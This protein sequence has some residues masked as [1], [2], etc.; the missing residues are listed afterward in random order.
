MFVAG[1]LNSWLYS[2]G[3]RA[4]PGSEKPLRDELL[5]IERLEER[6]LALAARFTTVA[7]GS[8]SGARSLFPRFN[9][10]ARAL[11]DAYRALA[12]DGHRGEFVTPAGEW[13]LDNYH[14]VAAEIR[15]VHQDL[16]RGYY[17]ELPKLA[18]RDQAGDARGYA[19]AV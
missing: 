5:S 19:L 17:R 18:S 15:Q 14:L 6:A 9:D 13:L 8:R 12:D 1:I 10:N 7:P 3:G 4:V 16:P 2:G 11:R